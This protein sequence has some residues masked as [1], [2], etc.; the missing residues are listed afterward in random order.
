M[1]CPSCGKFNH[2]AVSLCI[3]CGAMMPAMPNAPGY[4]QP[5]SGYGQPGYGQQFSGNAQ[6]ASGYG[7]PGYGQQFSGN[8]QQA[9]GYGQP[10]YGQTPSGYGQPQPPAYGQPGYG[11]MGYNPHSPYPRKSN[12]NVFIIIGACVAAAAIAIILFFVLSGG[13]L[14]GTYE[15]NYGNTITFSGKD[16]VTVSERYA[17]ES[18]T[19]TYTLKNNVLTITVNYRGRTI[20]ESGTYDKALDRIVFDYQVYY[21]QSSSNNQR[22]SGYDGGDDWGGWDVPTVTGWDS[23]PTATGWDDWDN[24]DNWDDWD[25]WDDWSIPTYPPDTAAPPDSWGW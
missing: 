1:N 24:W 3:H 9:S 11:Q 10:G 23:V 17:Y 21:K 16:K 19:G 20:S 5:S 8:A 14:S 4:T 25:D 2:A 12:T 7:Q 13:P 15:D 18:Y 6:Q 22:Y